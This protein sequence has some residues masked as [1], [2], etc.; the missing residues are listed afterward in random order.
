MKFATQADRDAA[1]KAACDEAGKAFA[2]MK[3]AE[4]KMREVGQSYTADQS[5]HEVAQP[6]ATEAADE[7]KSKPK[8]SGSKKS[9]GRGKS[10]RKNTNTAKSNDESTEESV[11]QHTASPDSSS[12]ESGATVDTGSDGGTSTGGGQSSDDS[13][14]SAD[15]NATSEAADDTQAT[16]SSTSDGENNDAN[17]EL[18]C[19]LKNSADLRALMSKRFAELGGQ[20]EHKVA[21]KKALTDATGAANAALVK[22]EDLPKAYAAIMAV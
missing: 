17:D 12:V 5:A 21:L 13:V 6:P 10:V 22:E 16:E 4:W 7:P 20:P 9:T 1:M 19:P 15:E 11:D 14:R 2:N 18:E 8:S 3:F